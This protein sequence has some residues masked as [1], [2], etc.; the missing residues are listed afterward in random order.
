MTIVYPDSMLLKKGIYTDYN[1]SA[2]FY[3]DT[4]HL[5]SA[6]S[7]YIS[8]VFDPIFK[9]YKSHLSLYR[10]SNLRLYINQ[11]LSITLNE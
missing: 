1:D 10:Y 8:P 11:N 9:Q 5:S 6:G 7:R 4:H 3:Y 2:L